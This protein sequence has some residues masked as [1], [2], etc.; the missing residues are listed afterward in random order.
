MNL[1]HLWDRLRERQWQRVI[2][3]G[4]FDERLLGTCKVPNRS[5]RDGAKGQ[6]DKATAQAPIIASH[7]PLK[8][9]TMPPMPSAIWMRPRNAFTSRPD[10]AFGRPL[11]AKVGECALGVAADSDLRESVAHKHPPY[12]W[13]RDRAD[14]RDGASSDFG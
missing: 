10:P 4:R 3:V 12:V 9:A 1:R 13:R 7:C 6:R 2:A 11:L 14:P 8:R 5:E